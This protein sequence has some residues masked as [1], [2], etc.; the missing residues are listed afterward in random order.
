MPSEVPEGAMGSAEGA[1]APSVPVLATGL[2]A[3]DL[4]KGGPWSSKGRKWFIMG[5]QWYSIVAPVISD[6]IA[7]CLGGGASDSKCG[8]R[9]FGKGTVDPM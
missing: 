4:K 5:R 9:S 1:I 2:V 6:M 8:A 3:S 7:G